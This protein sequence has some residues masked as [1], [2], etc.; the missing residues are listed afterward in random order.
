MKRTIL[1]LSFILIL[2]IYANGQ[3][4]SLTGIVTSADDG[5]P[6]PGVTV[7]IKGTTNGTV[8]DID[9]KYKI[10]DLTPETILV[11]SFVG[12]DPMEAIVGSNTTLDIQL[13]ATAKEIEGVVVTALG[14]KRQQREIG[15]STEKID[16]DVVVRSNAPNI[17]NAI[18]GR[19]SRCSGIAG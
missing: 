7:L 11:F 2:L 5:Q 16:A 15:Y 12:F 6:L 10:S 13:K 8:T 17:L 14:V 3:V 18:I 9:G 1:S 19:V 4:R